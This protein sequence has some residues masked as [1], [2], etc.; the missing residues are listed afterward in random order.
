MVNER[1]DCAAPSAAWRRCG[2]GV[3]GGWAGDRRPLFQ[4]RARRAG[5]GAAI[6]FTAAGR[7]YELAVAAGVFSAGRLDPGTAV[8]L[9]K[10]DLPTAATTGTLLDLGCG[11]GPI[12][13]VLAE[14][15]AGEHR[16]RGRR[17]ARARD[18][19]AENAATLGLADRVLVAAPDDVPGRRHVRA[20]L[21]QSAHPHRQG[22]AARAAGAVAAPAGAR[23]CRP[24]W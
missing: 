8:L 1:T 20:D 12:A 4:R 18:L 15:G 5:S 7:A 14:R 6:E 13:C 22:R 19:T 16:L 21:E 9:R 17:N 3:G 2:P 23:R 11:Y 24:G 10:G